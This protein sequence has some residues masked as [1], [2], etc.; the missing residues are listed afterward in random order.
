[1]LTYAI[2]TAAFVITEFASGVFTLP[3]HALDK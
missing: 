1:M 2:A 3:I